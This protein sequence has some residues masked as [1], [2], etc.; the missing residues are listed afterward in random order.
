MCVLVGPP[1]ATF[2]GPD[3]QQAPL[4]P[5]Q[6]RARVENL[7]KTYQLTKLQTKLSK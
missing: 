5:P 6:P 1:L 2:I 4:H 3:T 7:S